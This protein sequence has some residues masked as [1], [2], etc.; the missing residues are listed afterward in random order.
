MTRYSLNLPLDLKKEAE[1]WAARQ[2]VSLNKFILWAVAEKVGALRQRLD[3]P[4]FP[5][6][7][8]KRGAAGVPT[9]VI[10][11]TGVRVQTAV[12]ARKHWSRTPKQI[13]DD[14]DLTQTQVRDALAFYDSHTVE[15]DTAIEQ[16][17]SLE[18]QGV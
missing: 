1:E 13:A 5:H 17:Q 4:E 9:P 2:Q 7:T 16:E 6:I 14:Y 8:Y 18:T 15:I 11:G 12:I 10:R 3:D